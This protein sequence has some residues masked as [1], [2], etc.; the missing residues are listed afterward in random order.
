M[1]GTVINTTNPGHLVNANYMNAKN[2]KIINKSTLDINNGLNND[3]NFK[4][5]KLQL[6]RYEMLKDYINSRGNDNAPTYDEYIKYKEYPTKFIIPEN[7]KEKFNNYVN[8]YD[9][10]LN[11]IEIIDNKYL[12]TLENNTDYVPTN[13][14]LAWY[15]PTN[16]PRFGAQ[17]IH[18][19]NLR[20]N[21]RRTNSNKFALEKA[22]VMDKLK[23]SNINQNQNQNQ[24]QL[25][26]TDYLE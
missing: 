22:Q 1:Q 7:K 25:H 23:H 5:N 15:N 13:E 16:W 26:W 24:N 12:N 21:N 4:R 8:K 10:I 17:A 2:G 11:K 6:E 19:N 9:N 14:E 20:Y 3:I 18:G